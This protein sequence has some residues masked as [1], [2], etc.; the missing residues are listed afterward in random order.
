MQIVFKQLNKLT[1]I[2]FHILFEFDNKR[3]HYIRN[4]PLYFFLSSL[5]LCILEEFFYRII[6]IIT[7]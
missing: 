7:Y 4:L 5:S 2:N 6:I 1:S 3:L